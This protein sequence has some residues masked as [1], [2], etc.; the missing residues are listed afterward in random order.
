MAYTVRKRKACRVLVREREEKRQS[1]ELD[2]DGR[3]LKWPL[4]KQDER[5]WTAFYWLTAEMSVRFLRTGCENFGLH[6]MWGIS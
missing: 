6:K 3:L 2:V 4:R 1:K 5:V